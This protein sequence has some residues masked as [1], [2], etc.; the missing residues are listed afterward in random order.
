MTSGGL[1]GLLRG[2]RL[3]VVLDTN[4]VVS[5]MLWG[6]FSRRLL[7]AALEDYVTLYCSPV[8][9]NE[10]NQTLQ[11]AKFVKRLS[12]LQTT[13]ATLVAHYSA[14][15]TLVEPSQ[16][17]RVVVQDADD[18]HVLACALHA[19]AHFIATGDRHLHSLGG[20]Y[21]GVRILT[22]AEAVSLLET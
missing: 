17:P 15:V 21:Q 12:F 4:V 3:R 19:K 6:G 20:N 16:V 1:I 14:S 18:D 9:I 22:P 10:F 2:Q 13:A 5:G 8:L 11:Y 7:E